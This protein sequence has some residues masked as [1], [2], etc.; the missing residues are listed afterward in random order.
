MKKFIAVFAFLTTLNVSASEIVGQVIK[1]TDGDTI[2][3]LDANNDQYKVRLSGIDAPEK[4]QAFGNVSKQSL[5]DMV[6]GRVVTVGYNKRD[7]YGRV[8][9]KV[10]L[11]AMDVNLEQV[12]RGFAWHYKQYEREQDVE[13]R[14]IYAQEEYLAQRGTVGLWVDKNAIPPWNF[15]KLSNAK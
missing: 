7:R 15:R 11:N 5:A 9:G 13:D 4:K 3:V 10:M 1:V 14:S 6:A 12:K 2:T 8:V